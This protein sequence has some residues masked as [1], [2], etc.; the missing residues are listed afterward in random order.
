MSAETIAGRVTSVNDTGFKIDGR[1]EYLNYS[2]YGEAANVARATVGE[3]VTVV[4]DRNS[5]GSMYIQSLSKNGHDQEARRS[6]Y[7]EAEEDG[8]DRQLLIVRQTCLKQAV[9]FYGI[10]N[11][12][13]EEC[14]KASDHVIALATR[15]ENW[16]TRKE[17]RE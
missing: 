4:V 2:K 12:T 7:S 1:Q 3:F 10:V 11:H 17:S 16:V 14:G 9:E 13:P 8:A 15:F 6:V 5:K